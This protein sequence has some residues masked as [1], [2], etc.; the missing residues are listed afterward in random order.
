MSFTVLP[1]MTV[2]HTFIRLQKAEDN[3]GAR[4]NVKESD[5]LKRKM[6]ANKMKFNTDKYMSLP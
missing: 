6:K 1:Q 3:L 2:S 4:L 5:S